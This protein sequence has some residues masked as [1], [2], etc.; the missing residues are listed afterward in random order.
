MSERLA[1]GKAEDVFEINVPRIMIAAPGSGSGKT[2]LTCALLGALKRRGMRIAAFKCG[3][4][5]IDPLFHRQVVG[6]DSRNLDG[7]FAGEE[8]LREI[9]LADRREEELSV[10]EGVMGLYDGLGGVSEEASSYQV[11]RA[12]QTPVI[13]VVNARGMGRSLLALLAGFREYDREK[14]IVGVILNR[15]GKG[16]CELLSPLVET[17]LGIPVLGYFPETEE[18]C[19]ESRH[20]GLK[21]PEEVAG[22]E[23]RI[24][25]ASEILE[26]CVQT[27]RILELAGRAVPMRRTA[28]LSREIVG[29]GEWKAEDALRADGDVLCGKKVRIGVAMDEAFCFYYRDNL[30]VLEDAGAELVPFSPLRDERLPENLQGLL[31]GGGYPELWA[32]RLS[33]NVSMRRAVRGA[34][35]GGMPS[36]AECGGFLY[37]HDG[38][39]DREGVRYEMCGLV[40]GSCRD[41][42]RLVRFGYV[43]L[44]E[45]QPVFLG[46]G[47]S[48]R[49]HEFHYY[50]STDNGTGCRACKPVSG[51]S[52]ECI[53]VSA[54]HWWGFAHL[55]YPSNPQFVRHFVAEAAAYG[56]RA[57]DEG[58]N[59][60]A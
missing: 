33:A 50:E 7:F 4:D 35:E 36:V 6:V 41:M 8:Q 18:L 2:L 52:W 17:E 28:P 53:H 39:C 58:R 45:K 47:G 23:K 57:E 43:E 19:L 60:S 42:G 3:P 29:G 31:L 21:L 14:L 15:V 38:L 1:D 27:D 5:Y 11:A 55:Y 9:F 46:E 20:L 37:L 49:G 30:R 22:L 44:S 34:I 13:L 32:E 54:D 40:R 56:M 24:L 16:M 59:G 10:I 12:L 51:K 48:I 26:K 25:R